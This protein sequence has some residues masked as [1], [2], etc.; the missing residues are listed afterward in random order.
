MAN[1]FVAMLDTYFTTAQLTRIHATTIGIA[2][3]GGLG[4]NCASFLVR[5]GF[6][7]FIIADHDCVEP[8]NLNRQ[9]YYIDQV[10]HP[11]VTA[12]RHN[13]Q[14]IN[15]DVSVTAVQ[16]R[17]TADVCAEIFSGCDIIVEAFDTPSAKAMLIDVFGGS[18][19]LL[20]CASGIAGYGNSERIRTR[21][22][23]SNVYC[24]GDLHTA[25]G[26]E[27]KPLAPCVTIAA[28]KQADLVLEKVL[29][30]RE[31]KRTFSP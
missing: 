8:S 1:A 7:R 11:K 29:E 28:A 30:R 31:E 22:I 20:V 25:V 10:G 12:L 2:G 21:K 9:F 14:R 24:I 6:T 13:L 18:E 3:A 5:S 27:Q 26:I 16:K 19:R 4:S 17:C 23:A 15:P